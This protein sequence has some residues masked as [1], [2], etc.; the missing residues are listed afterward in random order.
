MNV[1]RV[2][3]LAVFNLAAGRLS[4]GVN[5][6]RGFKNS[7]FG[8]CVNSKHGFCFLRRPVVYRSPKTIFTKYTVS[9]AAITAP[10]VV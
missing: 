8:S 6:V 4:F 9:M 5:C 10:A 1:S 3:R 2:Y 7:L